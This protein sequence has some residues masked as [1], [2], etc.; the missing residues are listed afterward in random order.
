MVSTSTGWPFSIVGRYF[1]SFTAVIA[2]AISSGGPETYSSLSI[3]PSFEM[4]ACKV[5]VPDTW[6]DLAIVG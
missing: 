3:E 6:A 5:T 2:D 4:M 1:H